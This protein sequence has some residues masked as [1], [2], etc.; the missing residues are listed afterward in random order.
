MNSYKPYSI[1][2]PPYEVTSGGIRVVYALRSW[3]ETKGQ[4]AFLNMRY[5]VPY[6]GVYPE[7]YP[8]NHLEADT[9]VRYILQKPGVMSSYG[10][11]G[12]K[13]F[14]AT[15]KLYVFSKIYDTFG[16]IDDHLLF[17]PVINLHIFKD[18]H[19]KRTKTCYLVGK[20]TNTH[21]H[22]DDAIELTRAFATN[23]AAL[24]ELL[25]ECSVLYGYDHM[26]AMYDIARLC[27]CTVKYLGSGTRDELHDYETGLD[28][29]DFGDVMIPVDSTLFREHY[30]G[31]RELFSKKLDYFIED[32][33]S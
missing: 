1:A 6:I 8:G 19:K 5:D 23:Q 25:N 9:V 20:G 29:I 18:L 26:S 33:Q 3:L 24:A 7:I 14:P 22:P 13:T 16:V 15:D 12:P 31:M 21:Q 17:L 10:V 2:C 32:T 30:E 4:I 28:G 27:G 11:P